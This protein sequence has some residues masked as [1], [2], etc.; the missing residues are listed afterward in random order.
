MIG[1]IGCGNMASAIVKGIHAQFRQ[2][3]F[4]TYTPSF[5][6][7]E[8]LATAVSGVAVKNLSD[9]NECEILII[10]CKPQ[11]FKTLAQELKAKVNL[12]K[13]LV[14]SIMAAISAKKIAEELDTQLITRVMP[15]TPALILEG[16]SLIYHSPQVPED[17]QKRVESYFGACSRVHVLESEK[18]FDQT[19]VVTGSGPAYVFYFAKT[20]VDS[21]TQ[22]GVAPDE[23]KKMVTQLFKGSASLMESKSNETLDELIDEVTSKGGVTIEAIN[24]FKN[25]NLESISQKALE[26]AYKRSEEIKSGL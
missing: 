8:N 10:A 12:N 21:L 6:R 11:Q 2:I 18:L 5:T 13:K 4:Y 20:M 9:L 22:W 17:L 14:L 26:A 3:K 24:S 16:V 7:A 15:N 25:A 1:V 23:A 19:T